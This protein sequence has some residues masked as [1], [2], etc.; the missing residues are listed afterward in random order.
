MYNKH[1]GAH[2]G[3]KRTSDCLAL[4]LQVLV[5]CPVWMLGI[6]FRSTVCENVQVCMEARSSG[7]PWSWSYRWAVSHLT[8]ALGTK[9]GCSA[10][11]V[12]APNC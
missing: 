8:W 3:Q 10:R 4:E 6:Q 1:S 12:S 7:F 9:L 11:A 5:S 2:G